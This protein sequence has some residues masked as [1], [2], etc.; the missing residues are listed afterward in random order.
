MCCLECQCAEAILSV[1]EVNAVAPTVFL[2][3]ASWQFLFDVFDCFR[4]IVVN[5]VRLHYGL[6]SLEC[7]LSTSLNYSV[8]HLSRHDLH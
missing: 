5:P 6:D 4:E 2:L 3:I 7:Q 8:L 1:F